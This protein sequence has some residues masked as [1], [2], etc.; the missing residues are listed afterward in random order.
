MRFLAPGSSIP[1]EQS[2]K[3]RLFSTSPYSIF[4]Q[5]FAGLAAA[6]M[7]TV[8]GMPVMVKV[9]VKVTGKEI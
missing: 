4:S 5:V 9:K 8:N 7:E 3:D 1:S 2:R 6:V